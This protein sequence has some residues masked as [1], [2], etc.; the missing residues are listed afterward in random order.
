[1]QSH[2]AIL[3]DGCD[4]RISANIN[5]VSCPDITLTKSKSWSFTW[6]VGDDPLGSDHLS[7][8]I[9]IHDRNEPNHWG[10]F[11]S[12]CPK[13]LLNHLDKKL[14]KMLV[15]QHMVQF[16]FDLAASQL[17]INSIKLL[18]TAPFKRG[19]R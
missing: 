14:F 1:M 3:N 4:I 13:L 8:E 9:N 2:F 16:Q 7:R 18:S 5:Y 6:S 10:D 17:M 15:S 12:N 11:K 19:V